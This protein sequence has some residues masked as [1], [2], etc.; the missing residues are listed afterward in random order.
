[1]KKS[2]DVLFGILGGVL[3]GILALLVVSSV[4]AKSNEQKNNIDSPS[5]LSAIDAK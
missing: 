3:V 1:M 4:S 5:A 2:K